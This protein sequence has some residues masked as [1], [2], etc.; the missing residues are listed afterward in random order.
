MGFTGGSVRLAGKRLGLLKELVPEFSRIAVLWNPT[1]L[2]VALEWEATQE[3]IVLLDTI[4]G[5]SAQPR[6]C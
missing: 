4:P 3:A 2:G 6:S 1:N 5:V